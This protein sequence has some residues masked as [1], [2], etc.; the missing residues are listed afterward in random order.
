MKTKKL[1]L[2][3]KYVAGQVSA[4][5]ALRIWTAYQ[6][7]VPE[8][9]VAMRVKLFLGMHELFLALSSH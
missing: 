3:D 7:N 4:T 5:T 9:T 8:Y 1:N 6:D 2:P